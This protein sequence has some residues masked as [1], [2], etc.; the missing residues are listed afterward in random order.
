MN[1]NCRVVP[2][3]GLFEIGVD[4]AKA[5]GTCKASACICVIDSDILRH[6]DGPKRRFHG[7]FDFFHSN[8]IAMRSNLSR[9]VLDPKHEYAA[10][11]QSRNSPKKK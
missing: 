5:F 8:S 11:V 10:F 4:M 9:L 2:S 1:G 3:N 6:L 7:S